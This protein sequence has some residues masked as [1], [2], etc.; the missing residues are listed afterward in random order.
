MSRQVSVLQSS[1][2]PCFSLNHFRFT[3]LKQTKVINK[4]K[5]YLKCRQR[6]SVL[7]EVCLVSEAVVRG[8]VQKQSTLQEFS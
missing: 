6:V 7:T 3:Q 4:M 2:L 5:T 1:T 8:Q